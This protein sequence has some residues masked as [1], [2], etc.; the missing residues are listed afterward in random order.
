M[1][2]KSSRAIYAREGRKHPETQEY[3]LRISLKNRYLCDK[4]NFCGKF[5][6]RPLIPN[7]LLFA[8]P[9]DFTMGGVTSLR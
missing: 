7:M 4:S 9:I 2:R 6:M 1:S 8:Y 5:Q 3:L